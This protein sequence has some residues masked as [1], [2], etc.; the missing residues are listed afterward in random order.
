MENWSSTP[1]SLTGGATSFTASQTDSL[2][3]GGTSATF[4]FASAK[5]NVDVSDPAS[6]DASSATASYF[7][8]EPS[9]FGVADSTVGRFDREESFV[10]S[11]D[12]A[13]QLNSITWAEYSGDESLQ[14]TWTHAGVQLSEVFDM[15]SGSFYTTTTFDDITIDANS[16]VTFTNVSDSSAH[17]SG[18]LRIKQIDVELI[19]AVTLPEIGDTHLL[20]YWG[21]SPWYL[22]SGDSD[23]SGSVSDTIHGNVIISFSDAYTGVDV[24]DPDVPD[25]STAT[26]S[27]FGRE[28]SGFGIGDSNVGRFDRG[29]SFSVQAAQAFELQSIRWAEYSGDETIQLTWTS[30]GVPMSSTVSMSTASF[31]TTTSFAGIYPDANTPLEITNVSSSSA[32]ASGRLRVNQIELAFQNEV[33]E[34]TLSEGAYMFLSEWQEWPWNGVSGDT[35]LSGTQIA[36]ENGGTEIEFTITAQ[37]GVDVSD[38]T[39]PDFASASSAIFGFEASGFGVGESYAGRFDREESI[40]LLSDHDY[41]IEAISWREVT[42][43]EQVHLAWTSDGVAYT[44]VIDVLESTSEFED[45]IV[46]ANTPLVMTNVSSSSAN[47]SGRLRFNEILTKPIYSSTPSYDHTGSD[48]FEQMTGVNL[49]G[50][51]FDGWAL[52]QTDPLEWDY[53]HSKGLDLIRLDFKWERIQPTL[54]GTVDFTDLDTEVALANARGMKVVLDMHN[55]ARYNDNLIG[56]SAVPNSAFADV[57]QKIADH[58]KNETAIYGYGIMNEPHSTTGLWPAAAQAATDSIRTVDTNNWIIVAGDNWSKA[59]TWRSSNATLDIDDPYDM[60]M[61]EAHVY[62]DTTYAGVYNTYD[63]EDPVPLIGA[64]RLHPFILWLQEKGARGFIGEYGIPKD[65]VRWNTILD[66]FMSH[67]YDYGLSGT[68]WA[69]GQDWNDY[70]LDCSP[71]SDYSTDAIQMEILEKYTD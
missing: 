67:M 51:A 70:D 26:V 28:A 48:G 42:G 32:Y 52:Y 58:Y 12:H 37:S 49:A 38:P 31:Y 43:D 2:Y 20:E 3:N 7:G 55:Y 33:V 40:T 45:F 61:Y 54:Y 66:N 71:S 35:T 63:A 16:E 60:L 5:T 4:T 69:A 30:S 59:S 62:F 19:D 24:S 8:V 57:W 21:D 56:S 6:P 36:A 53:Y 34:A 50:G 18:R 29:E 46:D 25:F 22:V 39:T 65:D 17:A 68:Y 9:G 10:L 47:A 13:F 44:E 14:I 27:S 23:F 1:W 11:A 41:S 15:S 64:R